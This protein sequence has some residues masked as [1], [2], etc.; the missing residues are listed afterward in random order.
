VQDRRHQWACLL[1]AARRDGQADVALVLPT[2]N[3]DAMQIV[4]DRFAE[5]QVRDEHPVKV[6][7]GGGPRGARALTV[8]PKV[9]LVLRPPYAPPLSPMQ[10][11]WLHPRECFLSL[12][13]RARCD[14]IVMACGIVR[15]AVADVAE[16]SRSRCRCPSTQS[17][18]LNAASHRGG[19]P[20][21]GP[22]K[23]DHIPCLAP[24][25][26]AQETPDH[27][28][29][30][31]WRAVD[32]DGLIGDDGASAREVVV[33]ASQG[34]GPRRTPRPRG[35]TTRRRHAAARPDEAGTGPA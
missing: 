1:G 15:S 19:A 3:A 25:A 34:D 16:R 27:E 28:G 29:K 5:T 17:L 12:R 13:V 7:D 6:L 20:V 10:R 31:G 8:P 30:I 33:A 4:L 26:A 21:S 24:P 23:P 32:I 11:V 2:V 22:D 9:T 35:G 18:P 14:A